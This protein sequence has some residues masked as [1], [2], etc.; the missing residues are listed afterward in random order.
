MVSAYRCPSGV[1][2]LRPNRCGNVQ[3]G[4]SRPEMDANLQLRA[5][6]LG[7][8]NLLRPAVFLPEILA[9]GDDSV[10]MAGQLA[11]TILVL[12]AQ[13]KYLNR[14][15]AE[16]KKFDWDPY[17]RTYCALFVF[18]TLPLVACRCI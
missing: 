6:R 8:R 18:S 16:E 1:L 9:V 11:L 10:I 5:P 14:K 7:C 13:N 15:R 2:L 4:P 3:L 12:W 17:I